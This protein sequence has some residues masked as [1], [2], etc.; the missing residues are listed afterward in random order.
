MG[1]TDRTTPPRTRWRI[2]LVAAGLVFA[3]TLLAQ[4]DD[5]PL[6]PDQPA[7]SAAAKYRIPD[8]NR[9]I[10]Q[11][12][13]DN[14]PFVRDG[15]NPT[16]Y[17]AWTEVVLHTRQFAAGDLETH[18]TRDL[19]PDD[20]T[21]PSRVHL[22]LELVR[23]DGKLTRLRAV[24]PTNALA[25]IGLKAVYEGRLVPDGEPPGNAVAVVFTDLPPG[26]DVPGEIGKWVTVDRWA[27]FA[28]YFF[29]LMA[30]P[31]PDAD[32]NDPTA[33]GWLK[34]PVL[35][36]R[37]LTLLDSPP[38]VSVPL[39]KNLRIFKL[40]QD[41]AAIANE[42]KNWEEVAAWNR[43]LLHARRFP[44]AELEAAA[45]RGVSFAD[46]FKDSS[47]RDYKLEPIYLE[48]R[49]LW[50]KKAEPSRRMREAGIEAYYEGWVVPHSEPDDHPVCVAFTDLPPG[51]AVPE[52]PSDVN[53][54][55]SLAGYS[56]KLMQ[57][58]SGER[59]PANR[60]VRKRAPLLLARTLT[61]Q[62]DTTSGFG[63]WGN[64]FMP[65]VIGGVLLLVGTALGLS[66]WFRRDDR[67][68]KQEIEATRKNPFEG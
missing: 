17:D 31:G 10:F 44:A 9:A 20:L 33:G 55:V 54:V 43:V 34:A 2:S 4:P 32:P 26:L 66:W 36:G 64:T 8:R 38:P 48:G 19:T 14:E 13:R 18:A 59:D 16:E 56:F 12:I 35:V 3:G 39:N 5:R 1:M 37:S 42:E 41:D 15:L 61:L 51:L 63:T 52:K 45:R 40:I 7:P 6:P 24:K 47:R 65:A 46:L 22:R 58:E 62:Q 21:R 27:T 49:L 57:Y 28:G 50:L 25:E 67:R 30:Y 11:G 68:A 29:K 60:N 23:F 53:Q